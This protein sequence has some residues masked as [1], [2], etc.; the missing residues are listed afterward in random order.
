MCVADPNTWEALQ[1]NEDDDEAQV[2]QL[3][4]RA[5]AEST[6]QASTEGIRQSVSHLTKQA[7]VGK[8]PSQ[9]YVRRQLSLNKP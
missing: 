5:E 3:P 4:T 2:L 7:T 6:V 9:R 8:R 1:R